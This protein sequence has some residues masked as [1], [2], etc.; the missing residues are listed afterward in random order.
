MDKTPLIHK[1]LSG[2]ASEEEIKELNNWIEKGAANRA[3]F[4]DIKLLWEYS[5]KPDNEQGSDNPDS[6]EGLHKIE[7]TMKVIKRKDRKIKFLRIFSIVITIVLLVLL[8]TIAVYWYYMYQFGFTAKS[9]AVIRTDAP[10]GNLLSD[11]SVIFLNKNSSFAFR[12]LPGSR[13]LHLSGEAFFNV[14]H[15][16]LRPFYVRSGK[17]TIK[18]MGASFFVRA[19][20]EEDTK[21]FMI[22]GS[23]EV[24]SDKN[25]Y[26]LITGENMTLLPTNQASIKTHYRDS[27]F[28]FWYTGNLKFEDELLENILKILEKEYGLKFDVNKQE[29]LACRFTGT[30]YRGATI[31]D[32]IRTLTGTM[33]MEYKILNTKKYHLKG[34]GCSAIWLF[35]S[36]FF[37]SVY[38]T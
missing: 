21:V 9:I 5:K 27:N 14:K 1:L 22:E 37:Y 3:E 16:S 32:I 23:A 17:V 8:L 7:S 31:D 30:F 18:I 33:G 2:K 13:K 38:N 28:A 25:V 26:Q 4:E 36:S 29:I 10:V 6:L 12:D 20:P 15:D 11:S 24:V 35:K 34:K 19:Y